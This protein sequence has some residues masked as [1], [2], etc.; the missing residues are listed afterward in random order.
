[1]KVH[2]FMKN[3][4]GRVYHLEPLESAKS[5]MLSRITELLHNLNSAA[6]LQSN[7]YIF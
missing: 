2:I 1:M 3:K 7:A 6:T 4:A 5:T